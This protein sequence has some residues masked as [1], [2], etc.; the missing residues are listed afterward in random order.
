MSGLT[1]RI[2][3]FLATEATIFAVASLIHFEV[4]FDGYRDDGAGIAEGVIA[5]VLVAGYGLTLLFPDRSRAIGIVVQTFALVGTFVGL[6]LLIV[7]GPRTGLD[8]AI[9][10]VM[11]L[12]V[13]LGLILTVRNR[14][15][16]T[17][18]VDG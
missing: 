6:I 17:L 12:V 7:V 5:A 16:L 11:V 18:D 9:H 15:G 10:V 2:R 8:M 4:L 14:S 1:T 13:G 3:L